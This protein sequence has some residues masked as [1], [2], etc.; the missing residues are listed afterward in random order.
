MYYSLGVRLGG[1]HHHQST[2]P[3]ECVHHPLST[4]GVSEHRPPVL[5][6]PGCGGSVRGRHATLNTTRKSKNSDA[7][8]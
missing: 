4:E 5:G 1:H 2:G 3:P 6:R 8:S 7:K